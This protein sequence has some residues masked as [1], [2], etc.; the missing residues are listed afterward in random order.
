[1]SYTVNTDKACLDR[2]LVHSF[3]SESYWGQGRSREVMDAA[4]DG[5]L[6]FGVYAGEVQVGFARVITDYATSAFLADVFIHEAHRGQGLSTLLLETILRDERL[7]SCAWT[8]RTRDAHDLY[9][10]FGFERATSLERLMHRAPV[11]RL[12]L[13]R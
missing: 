13:E 8:L 11:Q 9:E 12:P 2:A 7:K 1:M 5:S 3:I 6:C 10:K 4:I